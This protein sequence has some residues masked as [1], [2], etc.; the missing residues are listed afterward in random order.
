MKS[1]LLELCCDCIDTFEEFS[2]TIENSTMSFSLIGENLKIQIDS[3]L[4]DKKIENL[5]FN[6][7]SM[8]FL[9]LGYF[10]KIKT[11]EI[12]HTVID[13][14]KLSGKYTTSKQFNKKCYQI[15]NINSDSINQDI[16][17][18]FV[19]KTSNDYVINSMQVLISE[20]YEHVMSDHKLL[21]TLHC[22]D[23]VYEGKK[24]TDFVTRLSEIMGVT[25]DK[26]QNGDF[27]QSL[28]SFFGCSN[29]NK[30]AEKLKDTRHWYS[31]LMNTGD[32]KFEKVI[33]DGAEFYYAFQFLYYS[34]R[35]YVINALGL[36]INESNIQAFLM[37]L[38]NSFFNNIGLNNS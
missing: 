28:F 23:G 27:M 3:D 2:T 35:I 13:I 20:D 29:I 8:I 15:I 21:I 9:Y 18:Q 16:Y 38:S 32:K 36:N 30:M 17:N 11:F 7:Y 12:E 1:A 10:P 14:S 25:N 33:K 6:L 19:S 5:L 22:V 31:H 37:K 4:D 26:L 34:L 24:D